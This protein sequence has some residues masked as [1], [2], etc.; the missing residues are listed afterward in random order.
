MGQHQGYSKTAHSYI[1]SLQ[2]VFILAKTADQIF[3]TFHLSVDRFSVSSRQLMSE[4][5]SKRKLLSLF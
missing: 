2:A 3:T 5:C 1:F 4:C